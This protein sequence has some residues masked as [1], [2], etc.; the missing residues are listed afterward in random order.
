[1][2]KFKSYIISKVLHVRRLHW[3]RFA[4]ILILEFTLGSV[5][6]RHILNWSAIDSSSMLISQAIVIKFDEIVTHHF[7]DNTEQRSCDLLHKA[8][9]TANR[10]TV[11]LF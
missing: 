11:L 8:L 1:M 7:A 10:F 9:G 3:S 2:N 4:N 6:N 5:N